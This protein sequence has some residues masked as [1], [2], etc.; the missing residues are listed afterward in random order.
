M[1]FFHHSAFGWSLLALVIVAFYFVRLT[2]RRRSVSSMLLWERAFALRSP[3]QRW[4]RAVS[5]LVQLVVL[6]LLVLVL[7][8]PYWLGTWRSARQLVLIVDNSA[9]MNAT[10]AQP[11]R[12]ARACR[13]ALTLVDGLGHYETAAVL[14]SGG[15]VRVQSGFTNDAVA[16][17]KAIARIRPS[18]GDDCM[19]EAIELAARMT[20]GM[21]NPRIYV[22]SDACFP[23]AARWADE[24]NVVLMRTG[25]AADGPAENIGITRLAARRA[26]HQFGQVE[27]FV[28]VTNF[29]DRPG[30]TRLTLTR[31]PE[32]LASDRVELPPN[33]VFR[34]VYSINSRKGGLVTAKLHHDD[35]LL[36]DNQ[37]NL[38][39]PPVVQVSIRVA[40]G[41]QSADERNPT[42]RL[43]DAIGQL[44]WAGVE[45][46]QTASVGSSQTIHV[47]VDSVPKKLPLGPVLAIGPSGSCDLWNYSTTVYGDFVLPN[48]GASGSAAALLRDVALDEAIIEGLIQVEYLEQPDL[49][50]RT[51]T[52]DAILSAW[53][54]PSGR[55]VLLHVPLRKTDLTLRSG[56]PVFVA[57]AVRWLRDEWPPGIPDVS[58][59]D[60]VARTASDAATVTEFTEPG[61]Q[62]ESVAEGQTRL[63]PLDEV[64]VWQLH[65]GDAGNGKL[66]VAS[67]L[68]N[69]QESE[70][71][72]PDDV[73]APVLDHASTG[74]LLWPVFLVLAIVALT[75]EWLV[76]GCHDLPRA[77]N[78][79]HR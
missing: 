40:G 50:I 26:L 14:S 63:G 64:G 48:N 5:L 43:I 47:F 25:D 4:H 34:R 11:S 65:S 74:G 17:E 29:S 71:R 62:R 7:A 56:F 39:L 9:G 21:R 13:S 72:C 69:S 49:V 6:V 46:P 28:E 32:D 33:E 53:D 8:E 54:R 61:G 70:L 12:L 58:T 23:D 16:L 52:G 51:A 19:Q 79:Q 76:L 20:E 60:V 73:P 42:R 30:S 3:W 66:V 24:D 75:A 41:S 36:A 78:P 67:N 59:S 31:G 77:S 1:G 22:L 45:Q 37:A 27:V 2:R 10:D 55:I 35:H 15:V 44:P 57:N 38:V 68:V 18:D